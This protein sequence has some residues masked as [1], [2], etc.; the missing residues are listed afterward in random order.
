MTGRFQQPWIQ[1]TILHHLED[2]GGVPANVNY[3]RSDVLNREQGREFVQDGVLVGAT[4][5]ANLELCGLRKQGQRQE[6]QQEQGAQHAQDYKINRRFSPINADLIGVHRRKSA[7]KIIS[8]SSRAP[9]TSS[10]SRLF[11]RSAREQ[12]RTTP[13]AAPAAPHPFRGSLSPSPD[14]TRRARRSSPESYGPN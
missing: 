3:V 10:P 5:L 2:A 1:A 14:L 12:A 4:I 6:Q 13:S 9:P 8:S 7:A 11:A